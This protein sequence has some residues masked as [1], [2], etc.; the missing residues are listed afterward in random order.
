MYMESFIQKNKNKIF[1]GFF[2]YAFVGAFMVSYIKNAFSYP[3]M[4]EISI[5]LF[6]LPI[7][8]ILLKDY[9]SKKS[10]F[11]V[12]FFSTLGLVIEYTALKTGFPYS[13]FIYDQTSVFKIDEIL[14]WTVGLSWSIFVFGAIGASYFIKTKNILL[15]PVLIGLILVLFDLVL[16]PAA[17]SINMWSYENKGF[18]YD[19]PFQNFVGW[20]ITGTLAGFFAQK[21]IPK[22][23]PKMFY[24]FLPM[25]FFWVVILYINKIYIPMYIGLIIVIWGVIKYK[26]ER[27]DKN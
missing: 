3:L 8:Y 14:P 24:G 10:I 25:L 5:I 27:I 9:G 19:V 4:S 12:L 23:N 15:K 2:T 6:L 21:I 1:L 26:N 17:V 7:F 11:I 18:W 20:A 22:Q 16:D 13:N